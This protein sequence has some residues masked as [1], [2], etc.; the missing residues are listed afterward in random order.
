MDEVTA[1]FNKAEISE[2]VTKVMAIPSTSGA[3]TPLYKTVT[4]T[5]E[6]VM[7]IKRVL[8]DFEIGID[9]N[10]DASLW[11][12]WID[13]TFIESQIDLQSY[14]KLFT[15]GKFKVHFEFHVS[16]V[17][18][19]VGSAIL[20]Y[21][22]WSKVSQVGHVLELELIE[23]P[24]WRINQI[25][26]FPHQIIT[27]GHSGNYRVSTDWISTSSVWIQNRGR[28]I[29]DNAFYDFGCVQM[30]AFTPLRYNSTDSPT[31]PVRVWMW[32]EA[33]VDG[34]DPPANWLF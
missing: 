4:P 26:Q 22:P 10:F 16:S 7:G 23:T 19:H 31:I 30:R 1:Q 14:P 6:Q 28:T 32:L 34:W 29:A 8:A 5:I 18:Q 20:Y 3:E 2:P 9:K 15:F 13:K 33:E 24:Q 27:Y 17:F 12:R 11:Y 25:V 21:A